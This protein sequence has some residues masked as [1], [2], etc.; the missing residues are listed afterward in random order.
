[1]S[2]T[3]DDTDRRAESAPADT[4]HRRAL[5]GH[6][7]YHVCA[8]VTVIWLLLDQA[9]KVLAVETLQGRGVVDAGLGGLLEWE[10]VRNT[11][12]AFNIPGFTG[13]FVIVSIVV[14]IVVSRALPRTDRLSL[15]FAYGLVTGGALGNLVDR[16]FREP[17]FPD[18]GVIDFIKIGWWPKFNLADSGI[19]VGAILIVALMFLV[20][21]EER[22]RERAREGR[23]SVRPDATGPRG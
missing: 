17:G 18:G 16:L 8:G 21:R 5:P 3:V 13:M 22:A 9:T 1:M 23:A 4:A 12:A 15:A 6:L 7:V 20:D 10:L 2:S 19:V 11:N 14:I